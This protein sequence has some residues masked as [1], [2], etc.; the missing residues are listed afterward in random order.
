MRLEPEKLNELS[1][2]KLMGDE[3]E[4]D[5]SLQSSENIINEKIEWYHHFRT[6][7]LTGFRIEKLFTHFLD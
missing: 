7:P 3:V 1:S 6:L 5:S 2:C 4:L